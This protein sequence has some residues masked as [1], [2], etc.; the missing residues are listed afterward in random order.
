MTPSPAVADAAAA[1]PTTPFYPRT[2][3]LGGPTKHASTEG[4][5]SEQRPLAGGR[6]PRAYHNSPCRREGAAGLS[7]QSS[8]KRHHCFDR[9]TLKE[10]EAPLD[11]INQTDESL[12]LTP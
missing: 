5:Y 12:A 2:R 9:Q 8:L 3:P 6:E 7:Q 11:S 1:L 10:Q 4:M